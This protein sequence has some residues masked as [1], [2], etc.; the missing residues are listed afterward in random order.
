MVPEFLQII[1]RPTRTK[2]LSDSST[3]GRIILF[4]FLVFI[5]STV[6]VIQ[7]SFS[8]SLY[9]SNSSWCF[10]AVEFL[11]SIKRYPAFQLS[12]FGWRRFPTAVVRV[13]FNKNS[14]GNFLAHLHVLLRN[15]TNEDFLATSAWFSTIA[16]SDV[17]SYWWLIVSWL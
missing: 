3:Y 16:C 10:T 13:L 8:S 1:N 9:V 11:L 2:A 12:L 14:L 5:F 6:A 4:V 15:S 17:L 7:M